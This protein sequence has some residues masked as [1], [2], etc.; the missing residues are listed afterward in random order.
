MRSLGRGSLVLLALLA[1]G[2]GSSRASLAQM[3]ETPPNF[4][5]AFIGDMGINTNAQSVLQLIEN[6]GADM[7]IH[8]GDL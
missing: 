7:A 4:K 6:E 5:V 2:L 1:S 8:L 3:A